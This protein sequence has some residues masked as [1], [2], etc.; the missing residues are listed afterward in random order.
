VKKA[1]IEELAAVDGMSEKIAIALRE[2]LDRD[3][4]D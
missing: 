4:T 3:D 1:T 2:W